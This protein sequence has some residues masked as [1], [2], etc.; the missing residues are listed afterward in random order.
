MN[1]IMNDTEQLT[2]MKF[3]DFHFASEVKKRS[4]VDLN[5]CYHCWCCAGGCPFVEAMDYTPNGVIRLVQLGMKKKALECSAI[6]I[7]VGCHTCSTA[8]P[9]AIDMSAIMDILRQIAL[10]EGVPCAEPDILDFHKEVLDSVAHYGRT[11]KLEIMS[12]YKIRKRDWFS[13]MDVGLKMLAKRKLDLMPSKVKN[14]GDI[15]NLFN[16]DK[17]GPGDSVKRV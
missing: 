15:R 11:H 5:M 16:R 17:K 3:S 7:C 1:Q 12:R 14:I 2:E 13:D 6:W 10:E 9:M 4:H 8:C